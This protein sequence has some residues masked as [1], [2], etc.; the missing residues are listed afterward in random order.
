MK[1]RAYK[2]SDRE[3]VEHIHYETGFIG[4]SISNIGISRKEWA[5]KCSWYLDNEPESIFVAEEKRTVKGY[6]FGCL[7]DTKQKESFAL[8]MLLNTFKIPFVN[9]ATRKWYSNNTTFLIRAILGKSDELKFSPPKNSGH[10]HINL[11]PEARGKEVGTKLL[12]EF[13]AYAKKKG[14]KQIHADSF[15]TELNPNKNFWLKNGFKEYQVLKTS[16]WNNYYPNEDIK[17]C[18]YVKEL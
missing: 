6:L 14:V 15:Q 18:C 11:L 16:F 1:I 9:R 8:E 7:D 4:K 3:S 5:K 13:E 10:I 12:K 17:L 2:P